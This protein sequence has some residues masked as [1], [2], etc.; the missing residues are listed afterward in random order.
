MGVASHLGIRLDEYDARIRT[1]VPHYERMLE[2][3][4]GALDALAGD[5]PTIV[6]LGIG[7]G[8]LSG[9]CL[10]VRPAARLIGVDGDA[11][12]LDAARVRLAGHAN[13]DLVHADFLDHPIPACD[14]IV[15]SI[16]LHHI[17]TPERKKAF[18]ASCAR[19]LRTGGVLITADAFFGKDPRLAARHHQAWLEHLMRSYP[20]AEAEGWLRAWSHEDV[21]FPLEDEVAW[22]AEAGFATD[23]VFRADGFAVIAALGDA[24][25]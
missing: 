14:A 8:A 21:Y 20:R 10:A 24:S 19:A 18:Y 9:R 11:G 13:V 23:I 16:A 7:T 15:A 2:G 6:D 12:M 17:A 1:F 3:V 5:T 25:R 22:L 4:A